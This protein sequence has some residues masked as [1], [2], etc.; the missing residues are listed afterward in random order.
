VAK[1]TGS[2]LLA[3]VRALC[4]DGTARTARIESGLA[5]RDMARLAGVP[6]S[7]VHEWENGGVPRDPEQAR[8]YLNALTRLG[9]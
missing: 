7:N 2:V 4:H 3:R 6:K 1:N 5:V 8:R 9:G